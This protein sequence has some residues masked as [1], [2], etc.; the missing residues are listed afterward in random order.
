VGLNFEDPSDKSLVSTVTL[1]YIDYNQIKGGEDGFN[2]YSNIGLNHWAVLMDDV[3][4]NKEGLGMGMGG[5]MAII[6]SGNTS[7]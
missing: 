3:Q 4:Y 7:I 5:R 1:G 2:Y 6:D